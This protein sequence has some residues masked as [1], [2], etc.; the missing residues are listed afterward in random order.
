VK[1][2]W[3]EN[4]IERETA[5]VGQRVDDAEAA[6]RQQQEDMGTAEN[7]GIRTREPE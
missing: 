3:I 5:V 7:T 4:Y 1:Q 2:Q 6:I